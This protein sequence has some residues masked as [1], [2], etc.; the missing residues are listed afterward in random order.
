MKLFYSMRVL[1]GVKFKN[2]NKI[3]N[4]VHD[5]T[6]KNKIV[7][8]FDI[9]QC[10]IRY[11]AGYNDY[12]IFEF[13]DIPHEKR[14]TYITR[15]KNKKMLQ[16]LN[17]PKSCYKFDQKRTFNKIFKEYLGRDTIDMIEANQKEFDKFIKGKKSI[18]V[19]P[20]SLDSGRGIEKLNVKDYKN[21]KEMFK[22][23][24]SK[25]FG[26][27]EEIVIQH[28]GMAKLHPNSV[29]C[30][31]VQTIV[32][33]NKPEVVYVACKAGN[34]GNFV[35]NLGFNGIN[36]PVNLKT[37]KLVKYGRTEHEQI[38]TVHPYTNVEFEGYQIPL[39]KEA[40]EMCKKAAMEVPEVKFVGWDVYIGK[41]KPGIIEGNNFPDYYFWQLPV[42][43]PDRIGLL[44]FYK[45]RLPKL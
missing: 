45:E 34:D 8:F 30:I 39:F 35:D 10:A 15:F 37:G 29:N 14:K 32:T 7:I 3:I 2:L 18:I 1:S 20:D 16:M 26:V 22:Y 21:T 12:W 44:P 17:D 13:F 23:I 43:N 31:R 9:A 24:K 6:N 27:A 25:K 38:F 42:H 36:I 19:K 40:C 5:R 41:D 28:D 4:K 33:N 11:G